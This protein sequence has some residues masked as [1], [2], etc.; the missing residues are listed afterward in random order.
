MPQTL[1]LRSF[2][3]FCEVVKSTYFIENLRTIGSENTIQK[4]VTEVFIETSNFAVNIGSIM[5]IVTEKRCLAAQ[6]KPVSSYYGEM[7]VCGKWF[8]EHLTQ[9]LLFKNLPTG[10]LF[11]RLFSDLL[12]I[13]LELHFVLFFSKYVPCESFFFYPISLAKLHYKR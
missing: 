2:W 5:K 7:P 12:S 4:Y 8:R 11:S 6:W 13:N 10:E 1:A 9:S 3:E